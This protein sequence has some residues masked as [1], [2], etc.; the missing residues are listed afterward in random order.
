MSRQQ[1]TLQPRAGWRLPRGSSVYDHP[2][3]D[4]DSHPGAR[5]HVVVIG[6]GI[7]GLAAAYSLATD[8]RARDLGVTCT[9][10]E[11]EHR[12]GGKI[13][14]ER[15]GGCLIENGPDSFLASKPWAV[16]LCRALGLADRLIGTRPG[17][18]VHV[19]WRGRLHPLPAGMMF[20]IPTRLGP[21]AR[22]GLLSPVEKLRIVLDLVLPRG[23]A[24]KE[25][26]GGLLRRRLGDAAVDRLAGPLLGGIYAGDA[27]ALSAAATFPQ[28]VAWEAQ[29]R[30]LILA[31]RARWHMR[32][33]SGP[34]APGP[35]FLSLP[36][37]LQE[38]IDRLVASLGETRIWT[39]RR[40][41]GLLHQPG[42]REGD[43]AVVLDNGIRLDGDAIV[44][45]TPAYVT[46]PLL[47]WLAPA[48]AEELRTIPYVSTAAVTLAYRRGTIQHP[49]DGN[50]FVVARGEPL[51]ITA[52]T[53]LSS[54]WPHRAPAG[55]A[56][57]RCYLGAAGREAVVEE[58]DRR[59]TDLAREDLRAVM[60][61]DAA[62][63]FASVA[64]WPMGMPQYPPGHLRRLEAI[65]RDL[66][67]LPGIAL[68]GAGYRGIGIPD[69]IRQGTEAADRVMEALAGLA[70]ADSCGG[71]L[72]SVSAHAGIPPSHD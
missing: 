65:E 7:A 25:T 66:G 49:L 48:A 30:S 31:A 40:T 6:G 59:L 62:P 67:S 29:H 64:R 46:A 27:D 51:N 4:G 18:P 5:P 20:G 14:T 42:C 58:D 35:L 1:P 38:M 21:L 69:C 53:W 63:L 12:L 11:E 28:L 19:A 44:L 50:G 22:S 70:R 61:I 3:G 43:Y 52:C 33:A 37:G 8:R 2:C 26:L 23:H 39:G 36:G 17:S 16:E 68:A 9:L 55:I 34:G 56:L 41:T 72:D 60:G 45:A 10:I 71:S 57:L 47:E 13:R 32:H 24:A 54:K 15:R